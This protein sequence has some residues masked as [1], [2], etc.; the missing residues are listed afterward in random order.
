[1]AFS[2]RLKSILLGVLGLPE[3]VDELE[4]SIQ[5]IQSDQYGDSSIP[6]SAVSDADLG[7]LLKEEVTLT[8]AQMRTL[9]ASPVTLVAAPGE[10]YALVPVRALFEYQYDG[11]NVAPAA[12]TFVAAAVSL[13]SDIVTFDSPHGYSTGQKVQVSNSGGGLPTGLSAATDYFIIATS[14]RVLK[15]AASLADALAGTPAVDITGAGTG[16]QT[17][18]PQTTPATYPYDNTASDTDFAIGYNGGDYLIS[19]HADAFIDGTAVAY[20]LGFQGESGVGAIL[21]MDVLENE[22][23]EVQ[24]LADE[25]ASANSAYYGS[26]PVKVTIFYQKL[27]L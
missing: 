7:I 27:E 19:V 24:M 13:G 25:V 5:D 21:E 4:N 20:R 16:T 17:I 18:T 1:M 2:N 26:V 8:G 14:T 3:L 15:F 12:Q 23:L 22:A 10:G 9:N 11:T 6:A